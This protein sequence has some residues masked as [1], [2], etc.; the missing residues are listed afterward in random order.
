MSLRDVL[1]KTWTQ[2]NGRVSV[3]GVQ[4]AS[5]AERFGTPVYVFDQA[6]LEHRL[7]DF[8]AAMGTTGTPACLARKAAPG[9]NC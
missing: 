6:H 1:P 5:I 2:R 8:S 4:L 3:G 9:R 7:G